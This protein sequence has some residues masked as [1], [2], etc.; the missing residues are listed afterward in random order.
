MTVDSIPISELGQ[1]G[2]GF[3]AAHGVVDYQCLRSD[4][5][6]SKVF[7]ICIYVYLRLIYESSRSR[8][9]PLVLQST[10]KPG[11]PQ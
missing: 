1:R 6:S 10:S 11:R 5:F 9:A 7:I 2:A 3:M 8:H 4:S